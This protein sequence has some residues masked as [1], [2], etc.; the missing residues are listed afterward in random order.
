M[1][2]MM[3]MI[4]WQ[5]FSSRFSG[6]FYSSES[7]VLQYFGSVKH[8]STVP[9]SFAMIKNV[10]NHSRLFDAK[11]VCKSCSPNSPL[12]IL[13]QTRNPQYYAYLTLSDRRDSRN[14][15]EISLTFKL[16]YRDQNGLSPFAKHILVDYAV[17]RLRSNLER[18]SK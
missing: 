14:P 7:N 16:L 18:I 11:L 3:M 2:M 8:N 12:W 9:N 15:K 17:I 6:Y 4:S 10:T 5:S 13:A 1:M